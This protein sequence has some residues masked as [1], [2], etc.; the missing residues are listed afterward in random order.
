MSTLKTNLQVWKKSPE[1]GFLEQSCM[2][3]ILILQ[4]LSNSTFSSTAQ[5]LYAISTLNI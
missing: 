5:K 3:P 1:K 2:L 4:P